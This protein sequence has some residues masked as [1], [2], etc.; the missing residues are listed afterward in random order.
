[1]PDPKEIVE[2]L[3]HDLETAK[4]EAKAAKEQSASLENKLS[5][6]ETEI[7][8]LDKSVKSLNETVEGL[9]KMAKE[10]PKALKQLIREDLESKK[11][12]IEGLMA[13]N[14][15]FTVEVKLATGDITLPAIGGTGLS[16]DMDPRV[17]AAPILSNAF[18]VAFP[19]QQTSTAR[20]QWIEASSTKNVGYVDELATNSNQSAVTFTEKQRKLAKIAT[21]IIISSEFENW[22]EFLVNFATN[23]VEAILLEDL[24]TKVWNGAGNDTNKQKEIYGVKN[25]ATAFAA[26]GKYSDANVGD[27]IL[28]A[29]AQAKKNGFN[30]NVCLVPFGVEATL[31]GLKDNNGATLYNQYTGMF[32]PVRILPSAD[33]G[34]TELLVA[35]NGCVETKLGKT[36]EI[37]FTRQAASDSWR[38][39]FRRMAQVKVAAPEAKG[40][41]YVA[42]IDTAIAAILK[43]AA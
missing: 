37:E 28:D 13:K 18:L 26:L 34:N 14:G 2:Q 38:V 3:K 6:K 25:V 11:A 24:N 10:Q 15:N 30:A 40:I 5:E 16:L 9:K 39:D 21:Y 17:H 7:N 41:I 43:P 29:I 20:L 35:D 1:M 12:D 23:R 42:D 36:L 4:Q 31:R 8:N 32:G 27:V 33:L 22:F 19:P